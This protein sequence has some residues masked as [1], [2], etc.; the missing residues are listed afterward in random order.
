VNRRRTTRVDFGEVAAAALPHL[1]ALCAR[2]L[3]DGRRQGVEWVAKNP[4]R[5]DRRMGSFKIN[6]RSGRWAGPTS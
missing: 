6:L 4:T 5:P 2:W 3:P 1:R